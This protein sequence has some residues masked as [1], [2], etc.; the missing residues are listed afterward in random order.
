[1][2]DP[3]KFRSIINEKLTYFVSLLGD[4]TL[5]VEQENTLDSID[6]Y[7]CNETGID[8]KKFPNYD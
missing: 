2:V 3:H 4:E 5:T 8:I 1:M 7:I 6:R